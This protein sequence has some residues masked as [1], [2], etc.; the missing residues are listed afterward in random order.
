MG[1]PANCFGG[2]WDPQRTYKLVKGFFCH[3]AFSICINGRISR[4]FKSIAGLRQGDPLSPPLFVIA[5]NVLSLM[6][7]HA[8]T[9]GR[10][11]YHQHCKAISLTHLCFADDLLVFLDGSKESLQAV[12]DVLKEYET[13]SGLSMNLAKTSLFTS[14][15][16]G[17]I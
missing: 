11:R 8:A 7:N 16:D 5:M 9:E 6:L 2:S 3:P 12:L 1:L 15:I 14:G 13:L 17:Y 4:Y 10:F